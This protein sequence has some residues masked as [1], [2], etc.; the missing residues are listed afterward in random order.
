[1]TG[2]R[3][4]LVAITAILAQAGVISAL[5]VP[6]AHAQ[7]QPQPQKLDRCY[8]G[9]RVKT[10]GGLPATV[11]AAKGAGCTIKTDAGNTFVDGTFAAFML[12][13]IA[14]SP[15]LRA[16]VNRTL[17]LGEY[18]CYG[19]GQRVLIGLG[20]KLLAGGTYTDLDGKSRGRY[21]I[22]GTNVRFTGGHLD[23]QTGRDIKDNGFTIG[24]MASCQKW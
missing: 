12:T 1:M 19:S 2:M 3:M 7:T 16:P 5:G 13:P 15:A 17:P 4:S 18:A 22:V 11:I 6:A 8:V 10:P 23:G 14:G 24:T 9:Q 21:A 20:F